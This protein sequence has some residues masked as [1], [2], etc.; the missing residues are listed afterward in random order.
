MPLIALDV[1]TSYIKGAVVEPESL[2]VKHIHRVPFPDP[3][4]NL[5][6]LFFEVDPG[7][8]IATVRGVV[9][10][11]LPRAPGCSGIVM[12]GQRGCLI[13][14]NG[15]GEP[16]SN[17]I[18]WKDQRALMSHSSGA[19]SHFEVMKQRLSP[20]EQRQLGNEVRPSLPICFLSWFAEQK[21]SLPSQTIAA[22]LTDFVVANLCDS[23]PE[24]ELTNAVGAL[25]L[26]TR[27][28]LPLTITASVTPTQ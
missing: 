5:P 20:Q 6:P 24:T 19:G 21:Q 18:S 28:V 10:H 16:L 15:R 9:S 13:L 8:I 22:A 3:L 25:N 14:V 11:L 4:P 1:G 17:Y 12:C 27:D 26:E 23:P 2:E 7:Q